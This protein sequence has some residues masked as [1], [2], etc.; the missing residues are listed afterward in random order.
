METCKSPWKVM[1]VSF[2]IA[3]ELLPDHAS[4]FSRHDFTLAQLF[5]C[6][7]LREMLKL[8]YRK[9]EATL[10]D[11]DWCQRLGMK[12]V[13]DHSTLSRAFNHIA[14][15][16]LMNAL[17]ERIIDRMIAGNSLGTTLAID[18]TLYDTHHRS[19]HY[20]RRCRHFS[21]SEKRTADT[22][23]SRSA[24]RTPKLGVGI[25]TRS[26][27]ILSMKSKIGM[28]SDCPDFGPLLFDAWKRH[29]IRNVLAD[30]GYDSEENHRF[31]RHDMRVRSLI[32]TG[33]G[34]PTSKR[35]SGRYRRLMQSQLEGSQKGKPFGQR[36]QVECVMSMLKRNLG[37]SLRC[38]SSA[39]RKRELMFKV[40]VHTLMILRRQQ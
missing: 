33:A 35:A 11:T 38:R 31:A 37:D 34:R 28:G 13:P 18:S 26:H 22:R 2:A 15:L 39:R 1:S 30:A 17:I 9:L 29:R 3:R 40:V 23:R 5:A 20:E 32:K 25:D 10:T 4:K 24:K 6:L 7:A 8:S 14:K 12:S 16:G 27:L 21:S 36:A 19:R